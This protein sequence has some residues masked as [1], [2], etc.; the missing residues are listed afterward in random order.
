MGAPTFRAVSFSELE[1][2]DVKYYARR[3]KSQ[4]PLVSLAEFVVEHNEKVR[5]FD[6]P[7]KSFTILG[8]NNTHGI[9]HAYDALGKDI[10]QPYKKVRAGDFAYNPYRINVGSI[11]WVQPEYDGAYISPAYVVFS[12]DD[13]LVLPEV[14]WFILKSNFFN[15]SL[16]AATAGSVRMNLTYPL[17]ET[18]KIPIPPLPVQ[19]KIVAYWQATR[20]KSLELE[21][22]ANQLP[23]ELEGL[24]LGYMGLEIK[25]I[26]QQPKLMISSWTKLTKW[27][28][29]ATH[30]LN[31][32]PD[33]TKGKYPV[34]SGRKCIL[35]VKHGCSSS[36]SSKPTTLKVLKLSAVTSGIFLSDE[37]KY[38]TD[39]IQ[40]R[41]SFDLK[42]GDIL[43]CRTN[44]TLAYV[45][46]PVLVEQDYQ[47]LIFPDKLMRIRCKENIRPE[48][49]EYILST[50]VARPQIEANART[51]VGNH[52]IGNEDVFNLEFPLPPTPVQL[53]L[54]E[55]IKE[56]KNEI[57]KLKSEAITEIRNAE[58]VIEQMI[59]GTDVT[60]FFES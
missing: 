4:Y 54:I 11:G 39:K 60:V 42:Q 31:Q 56:V 27:S 35:E 14:F 40:Y 36:P 57:A 44:G 10:N 53:M 26:K 58:R 38:I 13:K 18:L 16:R 59:L 29:R 19:E 24:I 43:M 5:P 12:V 47:D 50:S 41:E 28:Q 45:G 49:L 17:L 6:S 33:V 25:K 52:A 8:V 32:I 9:F 15:Q 23:D 30:L 3:I 48:Y 37:A 55:K 34:V 20:L 22:L 7:E 2:W 51:A 21:S 1:R 46:R